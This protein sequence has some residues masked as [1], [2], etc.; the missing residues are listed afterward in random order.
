MCRISTSSSDVLVALGLVLLNLSRLGTHNAGTPSMWKWKW[1]LTEVTSH[2]ETSS[3]PRFGDDHDGMGC[4]TVDVPSWA[5]KL[6][7]RCINHSAATSACSGASVSVSL[8]RLASL[9][10]AGP[11]RFDWLGSACVLVE[12][13]SAMST[14]GL[15]TWIFCTT[16]WFPF[17]RGTRPTSLAQCAGAN[18]RVRPNGRNVL[19]PSPAP[20][21][22]W[23]T[24]RVMPSH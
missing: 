14:H 24:C 23:I 5:L 10:L 8:A 21:V 20:V 1:Y 17:S 13:S 4:C 22:G 2:D 19:R 12:T 6:F 16:R 15:E 3:R 9:S 7:V 11:Q 18:A